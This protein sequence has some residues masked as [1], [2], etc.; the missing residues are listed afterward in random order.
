VAVGRVV[1]RSTTL[2]LAAGVLTFLDPAPTVTVGTGT[3]RL[4]W[5]PRSAFS[6]SPYVRLDRE[7]SP[8]WYVTG[9]LAPGVAILD[10]RA[11]AGAQVV[12]QIGAEAGVRRDG[13]RVRA[14]LDLFYYQGQFDGYRTYGARVSL[15]APGPSPA[16]TLR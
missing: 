11:S 8:G 5:D 14:A 13:T 16:R 10:E 9:R 4:F 1:A 6:A 15:G 12:P 7:V 2:G 3:L